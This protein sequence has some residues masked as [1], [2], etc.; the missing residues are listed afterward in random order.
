M[1]T[2]TGAL[3][4]EK[5]KQTTEHILNIKQDFLWTGTLKNVIM[6]SKLHST[7]NYS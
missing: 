1:V 2:L 3:T 6:G 4:V 7:G 5:K